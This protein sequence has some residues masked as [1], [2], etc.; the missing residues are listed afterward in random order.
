M[1][2]KSK[3]VKLVDD[4]FGK[5]RLHNSSKPHHQSIVNIANF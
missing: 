1:R 3:D 4:S 5:Q 2:M